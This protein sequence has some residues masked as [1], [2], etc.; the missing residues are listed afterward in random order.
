MP[1][2]ILVTH[3]PSSRF[4]VDEPEALPEALPEPRLFQGFRTRSGRNAVV[5]GGVPEVVLF[6]PY[7]HA[8]PL[9]WKTR[10][11]A[12]ANLNRLTARGYTASVVTSKEI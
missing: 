8:T 6:D 9:T 2:S 4:G 12:D 7:K 1:Y 3:L 5:V 11:A 10:G